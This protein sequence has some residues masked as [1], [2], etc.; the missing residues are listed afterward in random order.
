M[1]LHYR[2]TAIMVHLMSHAELSPN[3]P[4]QHAILFHG[5]N[6]SEKTVID[7]R[8]GYGFITRRVR[9]RAEWKWSLFHRYVEMGW[10]PP[11]WGASIDDCVLPHGAGE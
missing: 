2:P 1:G 11:D 7:E 10:Y 6:P 3:I 9:S 4:S 8:N 5:G